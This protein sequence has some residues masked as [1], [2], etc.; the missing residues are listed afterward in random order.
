MLF[1]PSILSSIV[2]VM[3][4]RVM[5]VN[6]LPG[7]TGSTASAEI[8]Q[9]PQGFYTLLFYDR[10]LSFGISMIYFMGAMSAIST[11]LVEYGKLEGVNAFQEFTHIV[12]PAVYPTV[13]SLL[14]VGF[15]Q[16]FTNMGLLLAYYG[17]T[18]DYS[19]RTFGYHIYITVKNEVNYYKYPYA[20]SMGL[21]F[22]AITI[23]LVLTAK[24]LL[25]KFGPRED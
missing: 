6:A 3:I 21:L 9:P 25:E 17:V 16:I 4:A 18:A 15:A 13:V 2:F 12:F 1:L 23:P 24:Y 19:V 14:V 10:I 5:V 11:G 22:T 20:A 7:L 8:L